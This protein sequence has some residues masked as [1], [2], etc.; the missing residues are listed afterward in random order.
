MIAMMTKAAPS[1]ADKGRKQQDELRKSA[2][3]SQDAL[4]VALN[5]RLPQTATS[6]SLLLLAGLLLL[7]V[8]LL[9]RR[10]GRA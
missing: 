1:P 8:A 4:L 5:Q 7:G 3:T 10:R 9:L 6:A 2:P